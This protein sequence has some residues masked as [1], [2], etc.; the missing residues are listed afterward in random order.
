VRAI[1]VLVVDDS[2]FTRKVVRE[3][4]EAQPDLEVVAIARDGLEALEKVQEFAPDVITLD[5]LMPNLDGLGFLRALPSP[6]PRVLVVST[7]DADSELG[8][9]ALSLGALDVVKKPTALASGQLY[10]LGQELVR[11]VRVAASARPTPLVAPGPPPA[12]HAPRQRTSGVE[13]VV[14]GTSTGGPHALSRLLVALPAD[15]P[16]PLLAALHIPVGYTKALAQRLDE[17]CSLRVVEAHDGLTIGPGLA[18]IARG[19]SDLELGP[20]STVRVRKGASLHAPSVD[21][22]FTS[23]AAVH[24]PGVLGVVM[25]GMG[26]D[27]T[28]GAR[29]IRAAG[30]RVITEAASSCVV[31]GM[32]RCVVE[33][34]LSD[35]EAPL[36]LLAAEILSRL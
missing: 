19:G 20:A 9:E 24:G 25:T 31:Y 8:V 34:G 26:D 27:G 22:L 14:V 4:L 13:V 15:L 36:E 35:A 18:V 11:K 33:A 12:L 6:G 1:K 32:P 2:A 16:V 10:E 28:A 17:G 29:A 23:A 30:G 5:L 3:V 7:S 21:A